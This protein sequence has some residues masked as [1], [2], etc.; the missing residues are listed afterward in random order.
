MFQDVV[1][2]LEVVD[3]PQSLIKVG[4]KL[5]CIGEFPICDAISAYQR[6][7]TT[8]DKPQDPITALNIILGLLAY[9][10]LKCTLV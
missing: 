6:S 10:V 3:I 8:V 5:Q 2:V 9:V 7:G 4:I 1:E